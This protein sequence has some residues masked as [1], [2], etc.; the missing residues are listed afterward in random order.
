MLS[1]HLNNLVFRVDELDVRN[2]HANGITLRIRLPGTH[3]NT[4]TQVM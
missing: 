4:H 3:T 2:G 1:T